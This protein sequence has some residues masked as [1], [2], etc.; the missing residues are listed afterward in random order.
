ELELAPLVPGAP[1]ARL[2]ES[3]RRLEELHAAAIFPED[4]AAAIHTA[5]ERL[6]RGPVAV[7]SSAAEEDRADRSA[8]GL[9]KT[10][11]D[12]RGDEVVLAA[13]KECWAS[14]YGEA[15]LAYRLD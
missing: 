11:L 12:V 4:L 10:V 3:A 15:A 8:A 2:R 7:R 9:F 5:Y 6:G 1:L 14:L 13:I